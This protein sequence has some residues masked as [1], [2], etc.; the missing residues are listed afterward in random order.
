M[1][2][3]KCLTGSANKTAAEP[4]LLLQPASQEGATGMGLGGSQWG[5]FIVNFRGSELP[6][7]FGLEGKLNPAT[8]TVARCHTARLSRPHRG[9]VLC[10]GLSIPLRV[11]WF[12][13]VGLGRKQQQNLWVPLGGSGEGVR[14]STSKQRF[15]HPSP[16]LRGCL[17]AE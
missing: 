2:K 14:G 6:V 17:A 5:H 4:S 13:G 3:T 16:H 12:D 9:S 10:Q 15:P 8:S 1:L 7:R 11:P